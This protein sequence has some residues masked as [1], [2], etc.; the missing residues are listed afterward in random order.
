VYT[1]PARQVAL[2]ALSLVA[3]A[4][5]SSCSN[6]D[7]AWSSAAADK[8]LFAVNVDAAPFYYH[9][10]RQGAGPDKT[11]P[12]DTLVTMIR[13]SFGHCKV[14]LTTGEEGYI[15]NDDLHIIASSMIATASAPSANNVTAAHFSPDA[16]NSQLPTSQA[17]PEFEPTPIPV[18][19]ELIN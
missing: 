4:L 5:G 19:P 9:G 10:P 12:K 16:A 8:K 11:L 14:R 2:L 6:S 15:A 7:S 18:P 3:V 1:K 17:A 13:P